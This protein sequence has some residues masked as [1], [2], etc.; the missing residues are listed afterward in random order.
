MV[1]FIKSGYDAMA[2]GDFHDG[3]FNISGQQVGG[4]HQI[5]YLVQTLPKTSR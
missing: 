4:W 1:D 5:D 2:H 3:Y